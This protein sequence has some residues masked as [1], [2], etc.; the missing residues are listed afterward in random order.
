MNLKFL[1]AWMIVAYS[2]CGLGVIYYLVRLGDLI[3]NSY[4]TSKVLLDLNL[5]AILC[6]VVA[7]IMFILVIPFSKKVEKSMSLQENNKNKE[8]EILNKYKSKK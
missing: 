1:K 8:I 6:F 4:E 3:F 2:F 7:V 5:Y